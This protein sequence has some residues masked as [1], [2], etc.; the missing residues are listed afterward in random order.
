MSEKR[1]DGRVA[2]VT[3]A[4]KGLGKAMALALAKGGAG[5]ERISE[6]VIELRGMSELCRQRHLCYYPDV[7]PERAAGGTAC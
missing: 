6:K 1:L 7:W 5:A 4:S 3:G 2:L